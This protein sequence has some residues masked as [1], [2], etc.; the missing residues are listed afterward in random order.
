MYY[1]CKDDKSPIFSSF[2]QIGLHLSLCIWCILFSNKSG[3]NV[4]GVFLV[5]EYRVFL[6]NL[7]YFVT[8]PKVQEVDY[9][10]SFV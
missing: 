6:S 3:G 7:S 2:I 5:Q 8:Y 4:I 10:V 9:F 1:I